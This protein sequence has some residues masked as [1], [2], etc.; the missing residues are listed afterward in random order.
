VPFLG[1]PYSSR[2]DRLGGEEF[3]TVVTQKKFSAKST[4]E[5]L[6]LFGKNVPK[7]PYSKGKKFGNRHIWT[8]CPVPGN[9]AGFYFYFFPYF[10]L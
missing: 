7:S 9:K 4:K 1:L 2:L 6:F 10:P 3:H 5:E 8:L